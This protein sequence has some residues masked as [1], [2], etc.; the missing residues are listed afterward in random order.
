MMAVPDDVVFGPSAEGSP[1]TYGEVRSLSPEEKISA[2]RRRLD[3][4]LIKQT[5]ELTK[6]EGG[7]RVIYSPF[8]L[9]TMTCV[10]VETL[11][12][13]LYGDS[14]AAQSHDDQSFVKIARK[15]DKRFS[16]QLRKDFKKRAAE[17]WGRKS[18]AKFKSVAHI[19]YRDFRN[20]LL[21]G[22]QGRAVYLTEDHDEW[23]YGDGVIELNPYWFWAAFKQAYSD[24][25]E[26]IEGNKCVERTKCLAYIDELL[27]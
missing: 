11:G 21:H 26:L 7:T 20:T 14:S 1:V 5:D 24:A 6:T 27:Q 9:A 17:R 15:L 4:W 19:I 16:D 3:D 12:Q 22:F 8:P 18:T 10:A 13:V 25:F 2:L 23:E